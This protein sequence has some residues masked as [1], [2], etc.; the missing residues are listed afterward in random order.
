MAVSPMFTL[1]TPD[2]TV[3]VTAVGATLGHSC[4]PEEIADVSQMENL[5]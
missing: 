4:D 3:V 1:N 5:K 2:L